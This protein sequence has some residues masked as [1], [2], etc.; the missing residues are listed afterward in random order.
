MATSYASDEK[1]SGL[2]PEG[3]L[4]ALDVLVGQKD[5]DAAAS[6]FSGDAVAAGVLAMIGD[7]DPD[8]TA[9]S[10]DLLPTKSAVR[11]F[12]ARHGSTVVTVASGS[13]V[14]DSGDAGRYLR[15]TDAS[16]KSLTIELD[17]DYGSDPLPDDFEVNVRCQGGDLTIGVT[18][19]DVAINPPSGGTLVLSDGMTVTLKRAA[20]DLFDL[21]GQTVPA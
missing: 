4:E 17:A 8:L 10:D 18:S 20:A 9:G 21:I 5:G 19:T 11:T 6:K 14:I 3:L 2:D 12:V 15:L 7:P 13:Y 16:P 1:P